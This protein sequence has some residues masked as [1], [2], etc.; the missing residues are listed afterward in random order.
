MLMT[1]SADSCPGAKLL[2]SVIGSAFTPM[3][4]RFAWLLL[5]EA[6]ELDAATATNTATAR[7]RDTATAGREGVDLK[8]RNDITHLSWGVDAAHQT[9]DHATLCVPSLTVKIR[10]ER[11]T[12][13]FG[14]EKAEGP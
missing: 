4:S 10:T 9:S 8:L 13:Y 12:R 2:S 1:A 14:T 7:A 3:I 11:P 5:R 6:T